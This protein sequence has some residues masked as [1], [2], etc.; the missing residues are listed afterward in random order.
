MKRGRR[1]IA[2][3]VVA[4]CGVA[5][6]LVAASSWNTS[7]DP[8]V[9]VA[10]LVVGWMFIGGG[11]LVW[12]ARPTSGVAGTLMAA[13]GFAW[14]AGTIWPSLEFLHRG[15]LLHLVAT[16]PDGRHALRRGA[17]ARVRGI[18]V[19]AA[20]A[21]NVTR[22]GSNAFVATTYGA[23]LAL[24]ATST[25]IRTRGAL[26]RARL[27]GVVAACTIAIAILLGSAARL[28]GTPLGVMGL[29]AYESALLF[30]ALLMV[31]DLLFS[32]WAEG[33]VAQAVVDLGDTALAGSVRE[34]LAHSLGD[35]SLVLAY[36]GGG[37]SGQFVDE[38]GQPVTVSPAAPGR[39]TAPLVAQGREIGFIA[40]NPALLA[41]PQLAASI[42]AAAGLAR[43]NST[44]QAEIRA[45]LAEVDASRERLV[46]AADA[47]R[48]RLGRRIQS[49]A[50]RRLERVAALLGQI[51]PSGSGEEMTRAA[52]QSEIL[53]AR[54]E[55]A[56]FAQGVHPASL[57]NS[58]LAAALADLARRSPIV[59]HLN[60]T[61]D[62]ADPLAEATI[63][64]VCSEAVANAAKHTEANTIDIDVGEAGDTIRLVVAD[65]GRGGAR[66][67]AGGG[68]RGLVDRVEALGGTFD[69]RSGVGAGTVIRVELPRGSRPA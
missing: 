28:V 45:R 42:S 46:H 18:A 12:A 13:V 23:I 17:V 15:P 16:Y 55:L 9:V 33:A 19:L 54:R 38:M 62:P 27:A 20:Y 43:T 59:T 10:D 6:G 58:G 49:G 41:D 35:P 65:D 53:R 30:A 29:Y 26:R 66:L 1:S 37:E 3:I 34:R 47:E 39:A 32:G 69:L 63:Y 51:G 2:G 36:L 56:D 8:G 48:R 11:A 52:L 57:T 22:L 44:L 68:L 7:A 14:F 31:L 67:N 50:A 60:V 5:F 21:A 40:A 64:F 25:V 61:A 4:G 24:V